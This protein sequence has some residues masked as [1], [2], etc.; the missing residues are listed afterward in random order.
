MTIITSE[1]LSKFRSVLPDNEEAVEALD[2]IELCQGDLIEALHIT[3]IID[4]DSYCGDEDGIDFE[5][6][7]KSL[8]KIICQPAFESAFREGSFVVALDYLLANTS[9]STIFLVPLMLYIFKIGLEN[10]GQSQQSG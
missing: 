7:T 10:F 1:E 8:R 9:H 5:N 4:K 3:M 2:I 6:I